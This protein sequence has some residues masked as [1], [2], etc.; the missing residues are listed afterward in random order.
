MGEY[1]EGKERRMLATLIPI[2]D[3]NMAVYSYS[4]FAQ[5][6][7]FFLNPGIDGRAKF[8]GAMN[9]MGMDMIRTIGVPI[10]SDDKVLFVEVNNVS[11][12]SNLLEQAPE[13]DPHTV[14]V[15]IDN[16]VKPEELKEQGFQMALK[17]V[18]VE[19]F[20]A[21]KEIISMMDYVLLDHKKINMKNAKFFFDKFFPD[22]KLCAVNIDTKE[23]YESLIEDGGYD[24]YEGGF[25]R[26]PVT[27]GVQEV[28]PLKLTY[29]ELL[30]VVNDPD[31]KL[32]DAAEV[33]GRDT[34]LV[35]S[36]LE[37]VNH[38]A[39]NSEIKSVQHAAAMLGQKELRRWINT[40][41]A[42]ELC[43]DKPSEIMR[44][45]LLRAK[46]AENLGKLF[47]LGGLSS[48]L[49]LMGLFSVLDLILEKPMAEALELVKVSNAIRRA[50]L[51][52][53]GELAP[54]LDF[55]KKYEEADWHEI[56]RIMVIRDIE[57]DPVYDAYVDSLHWYRE[58]LRV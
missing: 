26:M 33:I 44:L 25:F 1:P 50:L 21:Y 6:E 41:V 43:V 23:E 56:S 36:L 32:T 17:K 58:L 47:D 22:V 24:L 3:A 4:I 34:A 49:F 10:L 31:F 14:V 53:T 11:L 37:I 12:F 42:K 5:K 39:V 48:E 40:A 38:M 15:L 45:S 54:V 8:D 7:N 29:I 16:S 2:F 55:M 13:T 57:M 35:L 9:I 52:D 46:F 27:K 20:E 30:N 28:A 51:D 19:R 18:T